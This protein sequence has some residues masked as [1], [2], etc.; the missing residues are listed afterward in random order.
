MFNTK[1]A[2]RFDD[3]QCL[4]VSWQAKLDAMLAK[5]SLKEGLVE[6]YKYLWG[7]LPKVA[8]SATFPGP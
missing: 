3:D 4:G 8:A 6:S 5:F 2:K 1:R 7:Q